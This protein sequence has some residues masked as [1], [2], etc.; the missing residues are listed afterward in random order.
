MGST[1]TSPAGMGLLAVCLLTFCLLSPSW[2]KDRFFSAEE[3]I[4]LGF[5]VRIGGSCTGTL[6]TRD[7]V[8]SA[9]H[10]FLNLMDDAET[11]EKTGDKVKHIKRDE[12]EEKNTIVKEIGTHIDPSKFWEKPL[13]FSRNGSDPMPFWRKV[14]KIFLNP[15]FVSEAL[16]WKGSDLAL[17]ELYPES[18]SDVNG[19]VLRICLP[20]PGGP[21]NEDDYDREYRVAGY[22]RRRLPHCVTDGEGPE[23]FGICGRPLPCTKDHRAEKCGLEFLY[24]GDLHTECIHDETPSSQD[25]VCQGLLSFLGRKSITNT[26]HVLSKDRKSKITTCYPTRPKPNSKGWCSVRPPDEDENKEPQ[27]DKGWGFCSMDPDQADCSSSVAHKV[28]DLT[29]FKVNKLKREYC[30]D[31]LMENLKVEQPEVTRTDVDNLPKQFCVGRRSKVKFDDKEIYSQQSKKNFKKITGGV[32]DSILDILREDDPENVETIDG[33]PAC[34][35]DSGGPV[36]SMEGKTPVLEGVFS[37]MLWGT[38]RGRKEPTYYNKVSHFLSWITK[39]V[40]KKMLCF[41]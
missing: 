23:K 37:F 11:D 41:K 28:K 8:L 18:Y 5:I 26:I 31:K 7:W 21:D 19:K 1:Y 27:Y 32:T 25:P 2:S 15:D 16:S 22:G 3:G 13:S 10:C 17:L 36:F 35:G 24:D 40:P 6:I 39:H 34:F 12:D 20:A 9:A 14:K 30:V 29:A 33:G 38:C 4:Q